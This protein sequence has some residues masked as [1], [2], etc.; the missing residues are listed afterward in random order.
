MTE[1]YRLFFITP[2]WRLL[3]LSL[4]AILTGCSTTPPVQTSAPD[5]AQLPTPTV[6]AFYYD[7]IQAMLLLYQQHEAWRGTPYRI[8]GVNRSGI[9]CSAFVQVTFRELFSVDLPR[10]TEQQMRI[11]ERINRKQL[12]SGDL[13][14][15]RKGRHVGIYIENN[16]FLHASTTN[17]VM[18][19]NMDNTY[20]SRHF[21]Q[22]VSVRR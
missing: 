19:S 16:K 14:F 9:D 22:A 20:W 15:F 21:W 2:Q 3:L 10:T 7:E 17:G 11:G 12:Q 8:G 13:V 18:I 6:E 5:R 4:L 1:T